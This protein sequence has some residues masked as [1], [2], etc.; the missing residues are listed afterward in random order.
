MKKLLIGLLTLGSIS[1]FASTCADVNEYLLGE[2]GQYFQATHKNGSE[3]TS[4]E[5]LMFLPPFE[6]S[7]IPVFA[8]SSSNYAFYNI[9]SFSSNDEAEE[10]NGASL[11]DKEDG[12]QLSI[13]KQPGYVYMVDVVDSENIKLNR[14]DAYES[15]SI[16]L[17][18]TG[19]D[20]QEVLNSL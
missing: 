4:D 19:R 14:I 18:N 2:K 1:S 9:V 10:V 11:T 8:Q 3:V 13:W 20:V 5:K 15:E 12:C 6:K 16:Q 7:L 17:Q